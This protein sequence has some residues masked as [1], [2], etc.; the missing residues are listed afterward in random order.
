MKK[1]ILF[2]LISILTI[3]VDAKTYYSDYSE[4]ELVNELVEKTDIIDIKV[5]EKYL[6]YKEKKMEAFY[7]SYMEIKDMVKTEQT[8][9]VVS[10]WLNEKPIELNGRTI[11]EQ[12]L[13][14]YQNMKKIRYLKLKY[15]SNSAGSINFVE[16]KIKNNTKEMDYDIKSDIKD[17]NKIKDNDLINYIKLKESDEIIIY[18]KENIDI[19]NLIIECKFWLDEDIDIAWTTE[20]YGEEFENVYAKTIN[21]SKV[22]QESDNYILYVINQSH[23]DL[24]NPLYDKKSLSETKI[25]Q[26]K[27]NIVNLVTKYKKEDLYIKYE[28]VEREYL[29]DYYTEPING[30]KLDLDSIKEFYYVRKRDKVEIKDDLVIDNY[31]TKLEDLIVFTTTPNIKITSNMNYCKNGMYDINFILPFKTV[32]EK[33]IVDIKENY[34]K[35]LEVQNNY[36]KQLEKEN[37]RLIIS[38]NKL[39][40]EIKEILKNKDAAVNEA[41]EKIIACKY[42]LQELKDDRQIIEETVDKHDYN[43]LMVILMIL[44]LLF[45]LFILRKKSIQNNN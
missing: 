2:I 15:F 32:K 3:K 34:I 29:E 26:N 37:N 24:E 7:P 36:L 38:N 40:T 23:F 33:L 45:I 19:N 9:T 41:N 17:I 8:K 43:L 11:I 13:Y 10:S 42:Q 35:A 5:E 39:N 18:L 6:I 16:L 4:Y 21:S 25:E 44:G 1:I 22:K 20:L 31:D 14:E 27:F 12:K 30:Y 28:K